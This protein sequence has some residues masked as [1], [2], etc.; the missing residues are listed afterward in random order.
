MG[1]ILWYISSNL[2]IDRWYEL[3]GLAL[4]GLGLYFGILRLLGEFKKEDFDLFT[5]S[6]NI[7]KMFSYVKDE[8]KGKNSTRS[9]VNE[10]NVDRW[11]RGSKP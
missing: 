11:P 2:I 10:V 8:F 9:I 6:L 1:S 3:L 7:K 5:N 4:F